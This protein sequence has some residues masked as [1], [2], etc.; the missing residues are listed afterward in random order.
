MSEREAAVIKNGKIVNMVVIAADAVLKSTEIE[1][2]TIVGALMGDTVVDGGVPAIAVR[3]E[4]AKVAAVKAAADAVLAAK[5]ADD[6][7]TAKAS[8]TA[9]LTVLGLTEDEIA[10]LTGA[11]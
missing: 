7:A 9:K 1:Y 5:K 6:V 10:A 11:N 8:G 3:A 4:E 2:S